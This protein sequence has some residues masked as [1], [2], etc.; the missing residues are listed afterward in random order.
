MIKEAV[1]DYKRYKQDKEVNKRPVEVLDS[2]NKQFVTKQWQDIMVGDIVR[3]T[4][5]QQFPA[6]LVFLTSEVEEGTCYIETMNLDGETNLKIKKAL[7]QTKDYR[8]DTPS[9]DSP[10]LLDF[11]AT[12]KCEGPNARLYQFTGNLEVLQQQGGEPL[13][14]PLNPAAV[15][16]RGCQL[17]NTRVCYGAVIYAGKSL[18]CRQ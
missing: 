17:R 10:L 14:V 5:D 3:V 12:V 9:G 18:G 11:T 2:A 4:K 15:L 6:D 1:E 13:V 16:L 8:G 7:D